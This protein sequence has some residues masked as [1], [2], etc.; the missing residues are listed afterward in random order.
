MSGIRKE[1][2]WINSQQLNREMVK[3]CEEI[4]HKEW[5]WPVNIE[6]ISYDIHHWIK[7]LVKEKKQIFVYLSSWKMLKYQNVSGH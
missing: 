3:A 4:I 6:M 1:P 7:F 2:L 5:K